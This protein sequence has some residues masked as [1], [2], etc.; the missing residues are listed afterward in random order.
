MAINRQFKQTGAAKRRSGNASVRSAPGAAAIAVAIGPAMAMARVADDIRAADDAADHT[1]NH[2]AG[3]S[4]DHGAGAGANRD[5]FQRSGLSDER[6]T[7][8]RQHEQSSLEH[9]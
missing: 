1:A 2:R 5:A 7:G 9:R 3:R 8:Q 4:S 6:Q